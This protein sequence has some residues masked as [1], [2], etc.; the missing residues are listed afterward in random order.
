[1]DKKK[2]K[3]IILKTLEKEGGAAGIKALAKASKVSKDKLEKSLS[4]MGG[5]KQHQDGDYISTPI[6]E[7]PIKNKDPRGGD[8]NLEKEF[9][10]ISKAFAKQSQEFLRY[11][12]D[13]PP[14]DDTEEL[15]AFPWG[16][17]IRV[18]TPKPNIGLGGDGD[19]NY[20]G[21]FI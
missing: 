2:L 10:R 3:D 21:S 6:N 19:T 5:V 7:R 14:S 4:K 8:G 11:I 13:L 17:L 12:E 1:M 15:V 18:L 20:S 16:A 9:Q